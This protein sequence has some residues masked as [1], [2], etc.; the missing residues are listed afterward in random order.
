MDYADFAVFRYGVQEQTLTSNAF[1]RLLGI[2]IGDFLHQS[3][4]I[5][6]DL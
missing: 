3:L 4:V 1:D 6:N 5:T 2:F